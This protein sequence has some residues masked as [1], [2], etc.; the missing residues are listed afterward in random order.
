MPDVD[1][2]V[3]DVVELK[4]GG[5][6]M[7][8]EEVNNT[9]RQAKCLWFVDGDVKNSYFKFDALKKVDDK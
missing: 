2:K 5:P 4:S 9:K 1:L 3:G 7:T 8:V 6:D